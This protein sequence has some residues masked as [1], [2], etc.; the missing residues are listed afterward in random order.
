MKA[1]DQQKKIKPYLLGG[2]LKN[3]RMMKK[4]IDNEKI[5]LAN[6]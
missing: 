4:V 5:Y 1:K 6:D 2:K 3:N